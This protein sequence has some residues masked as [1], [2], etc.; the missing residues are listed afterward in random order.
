MTDIV[1][2]KSGLPDC[3]PIQE[4]MDVYIKGVHPNLPRRAGA[5]Y[6]MVGA[7]GSGKSSTLY[8]FFKK[9]TGKHYMRGHFDNIYLF[10]PESSFLSVKNH[11]FEE[12]ENVFHTLDSETLEEIHEEL[13]EFKNESL[14]NKRPIEDSLIIID[15][16]APL[17]KQDKQLMKA[18]NTFISKCRHVRC[19]FIFTLQAFKYCPPLL[20]R[21]VTYMSIWK[22]RNA[23]EWS[24]IAGEIFNIP[25]HKQESIYQYCFNEPYNHLDYDVIENKL[26]K[27]FNEIKIED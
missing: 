26:Y 3:K 7:G 22:P 20:R 5:V 12:H 27:N 13:L 24:Q 21:Q 18:L 4:A 1:E 17:L 8:N 9:G 25:K 19:S 15:D 10:T 6:L 2:I 16:F 23:V 14:A 11:P